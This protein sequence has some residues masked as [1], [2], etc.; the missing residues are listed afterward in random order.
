MKVAYDPEAD[1]IYITFRGTAVA[2]SVDVAEGVILDYDEVG[3]IRGIEIL[4]ASQRTE[5]PYSIFYTTVSEAS[6]ATR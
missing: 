4:R 1:A 2:R 3:E 6:S 5:D